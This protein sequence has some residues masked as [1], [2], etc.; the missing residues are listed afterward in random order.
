[1]SI[2]A[3]GSPAA[4]LDPRLPQPTQGSCS[5]RGCSQGR[6]WPFTVQPITEA[7]ILQGAPDTQR[8]ETKTSPAPSPWG[9]SVWTTCN[10]DQPPRVTSELPK[11]HRSDLSCPVP[12]LRSETD[13][14][15]ST[16]P[17][18]F[19]DRDL[20]SEIKISQW[21]CNKRLKEAGTSPASLRHQNK[22]TNKHKH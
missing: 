11:N 13:R 16:S 5:P 20:C 17:S 4:Y 15:F 22:Q 2:K 19:T 14:W 21:N 10:S 6:G 9:C 12:P 3:L 18:L 7:Q 1:M 8:S